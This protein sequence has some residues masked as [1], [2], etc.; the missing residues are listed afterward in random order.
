MAAVVVTAVV[1]AAAASVPAVAATATVAATDVDTAKGR[2][3]LKPSFDRLGPC[4]WR[5][6]FQ[7]S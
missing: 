3:R 7:S 2:E 5:I 4:S 6:V 1:V